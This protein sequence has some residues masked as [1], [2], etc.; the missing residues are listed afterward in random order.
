MF[1]YGSLHLPFCGGLS[2]SMLS[3]LCYRRS[4]AVGRWVKSDPRT[5]L[6]LREF[7]RAAVHDS[8][9]RPRPKFALAL[10]ASDGKSH[11]QVETSPAAFAGKWQFFQR[12]SHAEDSKGETIRYVHIYIHTCRYVS[13]NNDILY[14][15]YDN[16]LYINTHIYIWQG[17]VY[18]LS[19][20]WHGLDWGMLNELIMTVA[21]Y[22]PQT[23]VFCFA[24]V[25]TPSQF[26]SVTHVL[27]GAGILL[28]IL[29]MINICSFHS[30]CGYITYII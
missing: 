28:D 27:R 14:Y 1:K 23:A 7:W 30:C 26:S 9:R 15:C 22:E 18:S 19:W 3:F 2:V 17:F 6:D 4:F 5:V 13:M 12:V 21:I 20:S 16:T 29:L 11:R 10:R 25:T 24:L 8:I